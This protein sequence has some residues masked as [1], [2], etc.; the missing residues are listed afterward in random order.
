M[1]GRPSG[2]VSH[3]P[4]ERLSL[5]SLLSLLNRSSKGSGHSHRL[6]LAFQ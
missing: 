6:V 5:L 2:A 1:M 4:G 3:N